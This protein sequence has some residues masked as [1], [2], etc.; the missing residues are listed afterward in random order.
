MIF[1]PHVLAEKN[2]GIFFFVPID[3]FLAFVCIIQCHEHRE[4]ENKKTTYKVIT[5]LKK[6]ISI[7]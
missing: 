7:K 5:L 6:S 3:F 1:F 4:D 2:K